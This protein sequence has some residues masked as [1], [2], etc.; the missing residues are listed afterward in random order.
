MYAIIQWVDNDN[1]IDFIQ[2]EDKHI[3][4]F[5][6]VHEADDFANNHPDSDNLRVISLQVVDD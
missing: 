6:S 2:N 4:I 5:K 3:Y 1:G